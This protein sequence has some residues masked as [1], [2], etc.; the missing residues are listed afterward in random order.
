MTNSGAKTFEEIEQ[1]LRDQGEI[2]SAS[3]EQG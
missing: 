3:P 2:P 1:L